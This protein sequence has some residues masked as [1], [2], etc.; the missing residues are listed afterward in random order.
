MGVIVPAISICIMRVPVKKI[1]V[2]EEM[3]AENQINDVVELAGKVIVFF[4]QTK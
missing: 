1:T 4:R 3:K 2:T